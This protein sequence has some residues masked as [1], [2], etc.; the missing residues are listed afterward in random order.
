MFTCSRLQLDAQVEAWSRLDVEPSKR[1]SRR[2]TVI[3]LLVGYLT[4]CVIFGQTVQESP[5][6]MIKGLGT[7]VD[8]SE[9]KK[10]KKKRVTNLHAP[11]VA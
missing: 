5:K 6:K 11:R 3:L 4:F 10:K 9:K 7:H 1:R 8:E 2:V